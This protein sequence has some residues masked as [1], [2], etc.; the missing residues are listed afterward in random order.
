MKKLLLIATAFAFCIGFSNTAKAQLADGSVSPNFTATDINGNTWDLY[1]IL[2]QGKTVVL[3]ISATWCGP[4]WGFHQTKILDSLWMK[5]GPLGSTG[6]NANSTND[7]FVF[8]V[9]GDGS[10][11][12]AC[13]TSNAGCNSSTQGN[14]VTGVDYPIID[15][16]SI[17]GDFKISYYPTVYMIC[18][19]KIVRNCETYQVK[20]WY[21]EG[22][23]NQNCFVADA[24]ADAALNA[25]QPQTLNSCDS[26]APTITLEN[27]STSPLTSCTITYTVDGNINKT[28][29]WTGNLG[30]YEMTNI[31]DIKLG[32]ATAG[33]HALNV[34]V[35]D[36]NGGITD[37][38]SSNDEYNVS[39]DNHG[40]LN[41]ANSSQ[42]FQGTFPPANW[43]INNGGNQAVTW[44]SASV[45]GFATSSQ[46]TKL[47]F[48]TS[49]AGD[50]DVFYLP[51]ISFEGQTAPTI[52]FDIAKAKNDVSSDRLKVK[53]STNF[54]QIWKT[55]Y[56]KTDANGLS[57]T[58]LAGSAFVPA[59]ASD[60]RTETVA[61]NPAAFGN[62]PNV[63]IKFEGISAHGNNLYLDNFNFSTTGITEQTNSISDITLYP[64][65]ASTKV[66]LE[67][68][69][70]KPENIV[71]TIYNYLGEKVYAENKNH[72]PEGDSRI[73]LATDNLTAGMYNVTISSNDGFST[74][75]LVIIK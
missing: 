39:F 20:A 1:S 27:I 35:S 70:I 3:D 24:N 36:L 29:N 58:T 44:E 37:I 73:I 2:A 34:K 30:A 69:L 26:V 9:E 75:K 25:T 5:H 8:W 62:K 41:G 12:S 49:P 42:D 56:D 32:T 28:Y 53:A 23:K 21:Y 15:N 60:W 11:N 64:N 50:T 51:C 55:I 74:E 63:L 67:L 13:L 14:W 6:V 18:P 22:L 47:D 43:L 19:D 48:Y 71:I 40:S 52:T 17:A 31:S 7:M 68:T 59:A 57:T 45:G 16:A 10:T 54:G 4:C 46:S 61:L 72:M 65:P 33:T 66:N 38:R